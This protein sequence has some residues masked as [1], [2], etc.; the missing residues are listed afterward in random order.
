MDRRG[1]VKLAAASP[2]LASPIYVGGSDGNPDGDAS[3]TVIG[4]PSPDSQAAFTFYSPLAEQW[5][6]A[7][8]YFEWTSTTRNNEG[9][10]VNV[11]YRTFGSRSNPAL[12]MLHGGWP[13]GS[14]D[15]R[16]IISRLEDDYFIAALD[17]PGYGFSDKP[18]DGYSYMVED[19]A[20]LVDHFVREVVGLSQ[21]HI[22]T[23]S[24]GSSV[25]LS[26]LG[27]HFDDEAS[28]YE[29][30]YHFISNANIFLPLG[31]N[32]QGQYDL[33]DPELGPEL[34][35][36]QRA[37][38]RVTEG[39][40]EQVAWADI[41]AFNDGIG[42]RFYIGRHLLER[43]ENDFD[44]LDNLRRSP[45]PTA[46]IWG[47]QDTVSPIRIANHVWLEYLEKR[48]VESSYWIL[49]T[50]VHTPHEEVPDD[51]ETIIRACLEEGIPDP[52]DEDAY[53][54]E[55]RRNRSRSA[56]APIY[57]GRSIIRNVHFPSASEYT[58]DGYI[59]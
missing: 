4:S 56:T 51:L 59:Y 5:Y 2:A 1:F 37:E 48:A 21:F 31:N 42:A 17:F 15:Y 44:W 35:R 39:T 50:V 10:R 19:D 11:F 33:L 16:Q 55:L 53:M 20:K 54:W 27:N 30:T 34:I 26:L 12:V 25:G 45:I 28:P 6:R 9:R 47:L 58:P 23:H 52:E 13:G 43:A 40:P 36:Q 3:G 38:P 24:R 32:S 22:L 18:Q 41:L 8:Q 57:V 46:L 49:P 7:G 29:I 14:F